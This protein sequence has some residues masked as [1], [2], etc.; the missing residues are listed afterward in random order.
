MKVTRRELLCGAGIFAGAVLL[1]ERVVGA[2]ERRRSPR[3]RSAKTRRVA[4]SG[5]L[6]GAKLYGDVIA[7][8]NQ[9]EHR[10]ASEVDLRTSQWMLEQLRAAGLK[11]TFQSFPLRQFSVRQTRL[12]VGEWRMRAFPLWFPRSTGQSPISA[13]LALFERSSKPDSLRGKIGLVTFPASSGTAMHQG[14][15]HSRIILEVAKAGASAV[16]AITESATKEILL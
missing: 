16:V 3:R 14:S 2:R 13:D 1:G 9:G 8:Y 15:V 11:A 12:T 5:P 4:D 10:T 6:S 7:Y